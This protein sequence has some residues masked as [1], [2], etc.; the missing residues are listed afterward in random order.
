[1]R[2]RRLLAICLAL[3]AVPALAQSPA[4]PEFRVNTYTTG[5]QYGS[6]VAADST[7]AFVV[8][9][10]SDQDQSGTGIYAQRYSADG[11][12]RGTEFR[13]NTATLGFQ[14]S[15]EIAMAP[16]GD[17]V[18]AWADER[19]DP[20][21]AVMAQRFDASGAPRGANFRVNTFTTSYQTHPAVA[22]DNAGNFVVVWSSLGQD[23][24]GLGVFGQRYDSG[25]TPRGGEFRVN[26]YTTSDQAI[27]ALSTAAN[28]D[29]VVAWY[30]VGQDGDAIGVFAQR[31]AASGIPQG[32][33]FRVNTYTTGNQI[34]PSISHDA[35]GNFLVAWMGE[36]QDGS[37]LG[38]FGRRFDSTGAPRGGE[39]QV[40]T[41][42]TYAQSF[43]A[44]QAAPD[45]GFVVAWQSIQDG[46]SDGIFGQRYAS[47]GIR[48]G[49]EFRINSFTTST[50][51][52]PVI[53]GDPSGNMIV[54][55]ASY[56]Q[57][58]NA[59]GI[60]AQRFGLLVPE[61][62]EVDPLGNH[63]LEPGEA[64]GIAPAWRNVS[65]VTQAF[66]GVASNL[67]GPGAPANPTYDILDAAA[68][69]GVVPNGALGSCATT[70]NC[71]VFAIGN[72]PVRP[73]V[74]WD[75]TYHEDILPLSLGASLTRTIHIGDSFTDVPRTSPFYR[76]V[77]TILHHG[78]TGGCGGGN[79]CPL[80]S[81]PREQMAV[82]VLVAKEGPAYQ[83]PACVTGAEMF[84]D[85]PSTSPF[86]RWIEELAHRNIA[87]GC[88]GGNF[89]PL[90]P[91]SR[92]QM[93][94]FAL[95]TREAPGYSPA[96]C[97]AGAERFA[98]VP[99]S[100]PF[101]KWVEE[102]A[103]RNIAGGCGGGNFCPVTAVTREQ[104]GVF[105]SGTFGLQLY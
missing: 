25:G 67:T 84:A 17:F 22:V 45:G 50:Q 65:G 61:P 5:G 20:D 39:F 52:I 59:D 32:A 76:F 56:G 71:Y 83:P 46:S 68:D 35:A 72:P 103:R 75:A 7:G 31:F 51:G 33:E 62:G 15:A 11:T 86:C 3:V 12:P 94:V 18:I 2:P 55:W 24:Y 16:N 14:Q 66:T 80:Q 53:G 105:L 98:D 27:P 26:T 90:G 64:V 91:V 43:P 44:V 102:L 37:D 73:V 93:A 54:S 36:S 4:G 100:S 82:F 41:Y 78:L 74:H 6:S 87:G 30:S 13:V 60:Y 69:Y 77:E 92:E 85:V 104:N 97:V 42:T 95:A 58:G 8:T 10:T 96:A 19:G 63:V 34:S 88:G 28:G 70:G 79:F 81:T 48:Q 57:D 38:V 40:N 101:C 9:W 23:G 29:F 21:W 49:G 89:C 99:A 1:M 47:S